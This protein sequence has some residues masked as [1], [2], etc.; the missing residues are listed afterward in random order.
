MGSVLRCYDILP[1]M[2][3]VQ[4]KNMRDAKTQKKVTHIQKKQTVE[5]DGGLH[6]QRL[7]ISYYKSVQRLKELRL[8]NSKK[9]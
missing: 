3:K 1:E 8:N 7:Q 6:Q 9:A 4:R 5:T 2:S